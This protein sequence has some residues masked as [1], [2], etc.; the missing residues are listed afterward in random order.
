MGL[1]LL[2]IT[3]NLSCPG[4]GLL[5]ECCLVLIYTFIC[6]Q[7]TK[8]LFV[9]VKCSKLKFHLHESVLKIGF[10]LVR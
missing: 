6:Y 9:S 2:D 3:G 10:Y 7:M 8:R 4:G 5:S 1:L